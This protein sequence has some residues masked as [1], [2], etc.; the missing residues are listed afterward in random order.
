MNIFDEFLSLARVLQ[1]N[2][3]Q[4]CLIGGVA[5]AFHSLPRFTKDVDLLTTP[6]SFAA[7]KATLEADGYFEST[8]PWSFNNTALTLHRFIKPAGDDTMMI[9]LMV[10]GEPR[11]HD[12]LSNSLLAEHQDLSIPLATKED[13]IWLKSIRNS[14][15]DQ[16]DI[17]KLQS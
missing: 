1:R 8:Q 14:T 5:M 10:A 12:I 15:Q 13:L 2:N 16:A 7:I 11:H 4:Y 3:C 9:D 6:E 17:E